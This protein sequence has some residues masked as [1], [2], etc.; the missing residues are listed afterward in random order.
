M[1]TPPRSTI[2]DIAAQAGVSIATVSRALNDRPGVSSDTR[3]A[4]LRLARA[5]G[6]KR[7]T[8]A[9]A[10]ATGRTGLVGV[11]V[12]DI[13]AEYFAEI[14]AG[15]ASTFDDADLGVVLSLTRHEH[16]REVTLMDRLLRKRIDGAVLLL[17]SESREELALLQARGLPFVVVDPRE[18]VRGIAPSLS[19]ASTA[20]AREVVEHLRALGHQRIAAV[21]GGTDVVSSAARLDGYRY[22]HIS[23]QHAEDPDLIAHA[24]FGSPDSGYAAGKRLLELRDPPTAIFA[25]NDLLA[26]GVLRAA[27][28]LGIVVPDELSIVGFDD[29]DIALLVTPQLTTVR[30]PLAEMGRLA[31]TLLLDMLNGETV[32]PLHFELTTTLVERQ[33]TAPAPHRADHR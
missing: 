6:Y 23:A 3:E 8:S 9:R 30:Q 19:A 24:D 26:V 5:S 14:L 10:L 33:T 4:I 15:A 11:T 27:R 16:A 20:A 18:H 1:A 31:A 12:P 21:T 13:H 2:H 29:L 7:D 22:A 32:Q 25:F 17:P 28:D